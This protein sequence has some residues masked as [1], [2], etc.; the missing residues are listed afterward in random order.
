MNHIEPDESKWQRRIDE[1][2]SELG[3]VEDNDGTLQDEKES[4]QTKLDARDEYDNNEQNN[5]SSTED[6][7]NAGRPDSKPINKLK[8]KINGP[9]PENSDQRGDEQQHDDHQRRQSKPEPPDGGAPNGGETDTNSNTSGIRTIPVV[10]VKI[11]P[12]PHLQSQ[13]STNQ[14]QPQHMRALGRQ[15]YHRAFMNTPDVWQYPGSRHDYDQVGLVQQSYKKYF[16]LI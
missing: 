14:Q 10:E 2:D 12:G 7:V 11:T 5:M 9:T 8:D 6:T 15:T 3:S 16:G 1:I 13:P 4:L